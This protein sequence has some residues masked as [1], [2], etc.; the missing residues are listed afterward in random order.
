MVE[1][2]PK[3]LAHE[4]KATT[5]R[6]MV[7]YEGFNYMETVFINHGTR[8]HIYVYLGPHTPIVSFSFVCVLYMKNIPVMILQF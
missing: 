6:G 2:S 8:V 4:G 5:T 3:M 1:H 7:F